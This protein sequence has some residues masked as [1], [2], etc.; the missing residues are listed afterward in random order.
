M[1]LEDRK[2]NVVFKWFWSN[3]DRKIAENAPT[4]I[5]EKVSSLNAI[6]LQQNTQKKLT[7]T[8]TF[9]PRTTA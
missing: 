8:S 2:L 7:P 5:V 4:D 9:S 3:F 1:L 6:K